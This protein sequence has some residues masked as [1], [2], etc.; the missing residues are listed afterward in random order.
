MLS[1]FLSLST[2]VTLLWRNSSRGIL[3]YAPIPTYPF[4]H[5]HSF[6][7]TSSLMP[8]K[9]KKYSSGKYI[10]EKISSLFLSIYHISHLSFEGGLHVNNILLHIHSFCH[11]FHYFL[12]AIKNSK[13]LFLE[14]LP[15]TECLYPSHFKFTC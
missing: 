4:F 14:S 1:D 6:L 11:P 9:L 2:E 15:W 13:E 10:L 7:H 8:T 5:F 3:T 12:D